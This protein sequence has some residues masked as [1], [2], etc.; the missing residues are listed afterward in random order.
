MFYYYLL[1]SRH[2]EDHGG[3]GSGGSGEKLLDALRFRAKSATRAIDFHHPRPRT[4]QQ[5]ARSQLPPQDYNDNYMYYDP[6][7]TPRSR[8]RINHDAMGL[9]S[10]PR[11]R[12][13]PQETL[14]MPEASPSRLRW[15]DQRDAHDLSS[16][17]GGA[18]GGGAGDPYMMSTSGYSSGGGGGRKSGTSAEEGS[19]TSGPTMKSTEGF[20]LYAT[21]T[22]MQNHNR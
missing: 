13:H 20:D 4:Q 6:K 19:G 18:V 22:K 3:G 10:D 12:Y 21:S 8:A 7:P 2:L 1:L 5:P 9:Y 16:G 11:G 14:L 17:G 15:S